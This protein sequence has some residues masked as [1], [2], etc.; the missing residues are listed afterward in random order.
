VIKHIEVATRATVLRG[1]TRRQLAAAVASGALVRVRRDRYMHPDS[2]RAARDAVR[3]GGRLTCLSLLQMLGVFVYANSVTHVHIVRGMSRLRSTKSRARALEPRGQRSERLHW[4]ALT[5][6][7][8]VLGA[9][10]GIV[11]AL[12]HSVLCQAPRHA[13]A[14][15]DSALNKGLIALADLDDVFGA[16]PPRFSAL[17]PLVDG[18]AQSGPETL[19]R[20]M[21]RSL[22]C[23]VELQSWFDGV[24]HVDLVINGWLAVECDSKEFHESWQQQVK[25]RNRDLALAAL[26]YATLRLTAAQIMYRPDEV[27]A[28]IRRLV[29]QHSGCAVR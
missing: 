15:I 28:A 20:L 24:G 7:E 27:Q 3:I 26:G 8:D 16:L 10:V 11:D 22:G 17:R 2:P 13:L 1:L 21:A 6:P 29:E 14:T 19:V 25:D 9:A 12:V 18:R 5:R 4:L 23:Q